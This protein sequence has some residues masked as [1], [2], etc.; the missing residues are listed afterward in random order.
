MH[1]RVPRAN[2]ANEAHVEDRDTFGDTQIP[3]LYPDP[4]I[5]AEINGAPQTACVEHLSAVAAGA[6]VTFIIYMCMTTMRPPHA[7]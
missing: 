5:K 2:N 3:G 7:L 1:P 6:A 4:C